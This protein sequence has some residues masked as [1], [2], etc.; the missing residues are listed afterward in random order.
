MFEE[1]LDVSGCA[2]G[3]N[4]TLQTREYIVEKDA[5]KKLPALLARLFPSAK[6]LAVFDRN[7]HR[8]AYPK[9]A[10]RFPKFPPVFLQTMRFTRTNGRSI[11]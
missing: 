6:P 5:M 9:L 11:W 1:I 4:H 8:A 3:K 2:C 7:T 10:Q